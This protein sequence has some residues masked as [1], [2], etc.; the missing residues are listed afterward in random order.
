MHKFTALKVM[1]NSTI[2]Q[3]LFQTQNVY[4]MSYL[5]LSGSSCRGIAPNRIRVSRVGRK[6]TS[7]PGGSKTGAG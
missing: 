4:D 2:C 6:G 5:Y 3:G 1:L 7:N